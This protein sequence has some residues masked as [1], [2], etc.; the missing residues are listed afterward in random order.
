MDR[1]PRLG[2]SVPHVVNFV[3]HEVLLIPFF[4]PKRK[5]KRK[6]GRKGFLALHYLNR[7]SSSYSRFL[8]LR[9]FELFWF[10]LSWRMIWLSATFSCFSDCS[11]S[12]FGTFG[13][14]S[15]LFC[16]LSILFSF[17][18][19]KGIDCWTRSGA[20]THTHTPRNT[21]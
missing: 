12:R 3:C 19:Q 17:P 5:G 18:E 21:K 14:G 10:L 20:Q 11:S 8:P 4:F 13:V 15:L 2:T 7:T 9:I 16:F 6:S 1:F